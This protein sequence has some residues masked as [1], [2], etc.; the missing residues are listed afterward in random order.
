MSEEEPTC[1]V[2]HY[3]GWH[4]ASRHSPPVAHKRRC[5]HKEHQFSPHPPREPPLSTGQEPLGVSP[6]PTPLFRKWLPCNVDNK[7]RPISAH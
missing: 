1:Q 5:F 3:Q 2:D 6:A 7:L 4:E